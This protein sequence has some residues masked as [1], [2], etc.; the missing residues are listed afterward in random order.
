MRRTILLK[1]N[2]I[3]LN[4]RANLRRQRTV[5]GQPSVVAAGGL[6]LDVR[7]RHAR[8]AHGRMECVDQFVPAGL[9]Q[10]NAAPYLG[11]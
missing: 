3:G 10:R 4:E 5:S 9:S 11:E 7:S 2:D 8:Q 1:D 6:G